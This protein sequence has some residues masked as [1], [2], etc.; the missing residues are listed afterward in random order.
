MPA[1]LLVVF[2]P[3]HSGAAILSGCVRTLRLR[4]K[5][6]TLVLKSNAKV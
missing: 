1:R 4:I 2:M 5:P 6:A 3:P